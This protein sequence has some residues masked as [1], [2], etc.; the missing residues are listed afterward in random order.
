VTAPPVAAVTGGTGFLGRYIVAALVA[1]G[2]TVRLL[3]R[4]APLHPLLSEIPLELVLGDLGDPDA[5]CRLVTGASVVV[6]AA[7]LVKARRAADFF[8]VNVEGTRRLAQVV[9]EKAAEARVVLISSQ[10]ARHPHLSS[11]AA[12]KRAGEEA[13]AAVLGLRSWVAIRPCVVYGPWDRE[14]LALLRMAR[15][16]V[17]PAVVKPEPRVAMIHARDAAMAVAAMSAGG[18]SHAAFEISDARPDG[19]GWSELLATIGAALGHRP[20]VI[21]MPDALLRAAGA[22]SDGLAALSGKP[23]I[24]GRGKAREILH[25]DWALDRKMQLPDE[26]WTPTI[27][28]KAGI[29]E[30]VAWW[31]SAEHPAAR[32]GRRS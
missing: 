12:S 6:H 4:R 29:A 16:W 26:F 14:G 11:Y 17:A 28:L 1:S 18:P 24:F 23:A 5:L 15:G 31:T 9:A 27:T 2:W 13:I 21:Q 10:A 19:Y 32:F 3:T 20:R 30:T 8:A 25:R 22:A 7:G